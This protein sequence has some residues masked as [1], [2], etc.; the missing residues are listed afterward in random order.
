MDM[1]DHDEHDTGWQSLRARGRSMS[2]THHM[3]MRRSDAPPDTPFRMASQGSVECHWQ[4]TYE[5]FRPELP[6]SAARWLGFGTVPADR[7]SYELVR[8]WER[9]DDPARIRRFIAGT[10]EP[11]PVTPG[12]S[13]AEK[14]ILKATY[15]D[16]AVA[17]VTGSALSID[18]A[19]GRDRAP[20]GCGRR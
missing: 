7:P 14:A 6:R 12:A 19:P 20:P 8:S 15:S 16:L 17:A 13:I 3:A 9:A 11:A 5:P 10:P 4:A 1:T 2:A 18:R